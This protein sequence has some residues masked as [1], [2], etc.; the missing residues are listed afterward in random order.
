MAC[1]VK[2]TVESSGKKLALAWV[3]SS[4]QLALRW[5]G[6]RGEE[7]EGGLEAS[8]QLS[9]DPTQVLRFRLD[10]QESRHGVGPSQPLT[11]SASAACRS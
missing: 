1:S 7:N 5:V 10:G 4:R 8:D 11:G 9:D 3:R 2:Q 6:G